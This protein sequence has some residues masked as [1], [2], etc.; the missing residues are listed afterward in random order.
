M[1]LVVEVCTGK[2]GWSC[3]VKGVGSVVR[4]CEKGWGWDM[5]RLGCKG[6]ERV[7]GWLYNES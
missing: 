6:W 2:E 1:V 7:W 4:V 3:R 5:R